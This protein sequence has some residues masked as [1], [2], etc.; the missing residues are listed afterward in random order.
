MTIEIAQVASPLGAFR[1]VVEDGMVRSSGF[2]AGGESEEHQDRWG[3]HDALTAYFSGEVD[4]LDR[5]AVQ[6][7]GT[8]FQLAVWKC[9]REI[10]AG[11]TRSYR[12]VAERVGAPQAARAV[13]MANAA[14]P[15]GLIVPCH[16]VI[17][18]GGAIGGY[19]FGVEAKRWLL[20]HESRAS[21]ATHRPANGSPKTAGRAPILE[22][23]VLIPCSA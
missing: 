18:S 23:Q 12:D 3:V 16:R 14:N 10:P 22:Q 7:E 11:E 17:R 8:S 9:L 13:G 6:V 20:H 21:Q 19:G 4:A 1:A 5:V 2:P 15:V